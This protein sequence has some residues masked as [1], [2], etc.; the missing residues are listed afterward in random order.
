MIIPIH[1]FLLDVSLH[2]PHQPVHACRDPGGKPS[3]MRVY[4]PSMRFSQSTLDDSGCNRGG[5]SPVVRAACHQLVPTQGCQ[6]L[7]HT[8]CKIHVVVATWSTFMLLLPRCT[9]APT[10]R[11][12]SPVEAVLSGSEAALPGLIETPKSPRWETLL[13]TKA[14]TMNSLEGNRLQ[15]GDALDVS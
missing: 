2:T 15:P 7:S 8:E 9:W 11:H 12:S 10:K 6:E 14:N 1:S 4:C 3:G 13:L 5:P